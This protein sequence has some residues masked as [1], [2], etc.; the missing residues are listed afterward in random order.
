MLIGGGR[1]AEFRSHQNGVW[2][3]ARNYLGPKVPYDRMSGTSTTNPRRFGGFLPITVQG[4]FRCVQSG[5]AQTVILSTRSLGSP[6]GTKI[7]LSLHH[8][9]HLHSLR[10]PQSLPLRPN[11]LRSRNSTR[12]TSS[13]SSTDME[14]TS[15]SLF[16]H[17]LTRFL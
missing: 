8:I 15:E 7:P 17:S 6:V 5:S 1:T 14:L 16:P 13:N 9:H 4:I 12:Q 11:P 10:W 2:L 3:A